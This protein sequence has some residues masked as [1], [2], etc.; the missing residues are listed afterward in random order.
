MITGATGQYGKVV[1]EEL[2][3]KGINKNCIYGL[4]RDKSKAE[5]LKYLGINIVLGDYNDYD[6]LIFAFSSIHKLLF[7]SSGELQNR[8]EQHLKVIN[9]AK[10]SD[11][12]H[13]VYTSQI[14]KAVS[15][16]SPMN[17]VM[18]SHLATEK[19]IIKSNMNY[20]ILRNGL[21]LDMLPHFL[22]KKV[23]ENGLFIPAGQGK[24]AFTLRSELAQSAANILISEEHKNK[25][26]DICGEA[27]SFL[28]IASIIYQISNKNITYVSPD[29][30]TF[31]KMTVD[32]GIPI[33]QA[34]MIGSFALA[35]QQG[36]LESK[37]PNVN[38]FLGRNATS[39]QEFLEKIYK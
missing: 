36:E 8:T 4:V 2:I 12:K 9:A 37:N 19:A 13:I 35:A 29:I 34:K 31:I 1:I 33:E 30:D 39:V 24:I 20:T 18:E 23:I 6:S 25:I 5:S 21:Y 11:I 32:S 3:E 28:E 17:F 15:P 26:Y 22:G 38:Y 10:E 16:T 27:V 14:H 7:V